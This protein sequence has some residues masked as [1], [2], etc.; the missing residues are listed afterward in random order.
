MKNPWFALV[1]A[2]LLGQVKQSLAPNEMAQGR[3]E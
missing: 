2:A 1:V 3:M